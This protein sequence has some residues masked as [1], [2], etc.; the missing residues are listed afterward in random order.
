MTLTYENTRFFGSK[1]F[2]MEGIRNVI[3]VINQDVN[4]HI[5][6]RDVPL[7]RTGVP[8]AAP[9]HGGNMFPLF[10]PVHIVRAA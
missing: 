9:P 1:T 3:R 8:I 5:S 4:E 10:L 6:S 2:F 7:Q